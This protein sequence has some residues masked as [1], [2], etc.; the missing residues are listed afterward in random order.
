MEPTQSWKVRKT[1]NHRRR[2]SML[3]GMQLVVVVV[4]VVVVLGSLSRRG[5]L[6][7]VWLV[8]AVTAKLVV[9]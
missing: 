6:A 4:V 7:V 9:L 2:R 8:V 3:V 5:P 1:A